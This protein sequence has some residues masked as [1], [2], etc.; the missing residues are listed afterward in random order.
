MQRRRHHYMHG[1]RYRYR[2]PCPVISVGNLTTGGTGKTPL[3]RWLAHHLLAQGHQPAI[4]SRG[5]GQQSQQS[6]TAVSDL[7][8]LR[9]HPPMAADEAYL[10]ARA[11][12]GVAVL[13]GAQRQTVIEA[14]LHNGWCDTLLLDDAFQ[15]LRV[16]RDLDL[17]LLDARHPLGNGRMLPGGVLREH[18]RTL[19]HA[20]LIILT[21]A[22]DP[23]RARQAEQLIAPYLKAQTPILRATHAPAGWHHLDGSSCPM[24]HQPVLAFTGIGRPESFWHTL[25]TQGVRP[26]AHRAFADHYPFSATTLSELALQAQQ[27]GA[28]ALVCTEKDAVKLQPQW[29]PLPIYWLGVEWHFITDPAPLLQ[30]IKTLF[31]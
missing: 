31:W 16:Q 13:T 21:R 10:L 2:P 8:Q 4:I 20:D 22:E 17:L 14:A 3:I 28:S 27:A 7:E 23:Q 30:R 25:A 29:S 18:P 24:P 26:L 6:V 9:C 11:L 12:P 15:H 5:Y 1:H 19:Q